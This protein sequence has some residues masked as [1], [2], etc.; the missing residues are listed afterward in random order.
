V[1]KIFGIFL[2]PKYLK[3]ASISNMAAEKE[4]AYIERGVENRK[5]TERT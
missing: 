1:H 2:L 5:L 4:V 3:I